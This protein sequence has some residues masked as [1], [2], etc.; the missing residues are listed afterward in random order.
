MKRAVLPRHCV[1]LLFL[2]TMGGMKPLSRLV[3]L[4]VLVFCVFTARAAGK[5]NIVF[6]LSDDHSYPYLGCYGYEG[7]KT[8]HLDRFAAEGIKFHRAFTASP[9]CV[10]SRASIMTG[11]S[12]VA[13]RITRF[14]SPLPKDEITF[15]EILKQQAGYFVGVLGRT[16]HLDGSGR[17]PDVSDKVIEEHGLKTFKQRFD[18]VDATGQENIPK[19]MKEYF[20]QRP[21]DKPY[22]LWVN[23]SD[24]H[25]PWNT[26]KNPPDPAKLK[27]PGFLPDLPGLRDD[28]S[29]Y[30][31]EIEHMDGDFKTVLDIIQDRSGLENTL[32]LFMGDNGM[33]FPSGKGSLHDPGLNVPLLAWWPGVIKPGGESRNLISGED[34]APTCL[35]AAGLSV[36][37]RISGV[38]FLP[39][40]RGE[41]FKGRAHI[42]GERGPHGG[43]TFTANTAANAV[44]YSRAARSA[45]YKLIYNVTPNLRYLP[46]DSTGDPGWKEMTAA[47]EKNLLASEFEKLYFTSPRPVYELYDLEK[48]PSELDN[49]AG[50]KELAGVERELKEALQQ[51]MILDYDYLPL[52]IAAD[53]KGA[54][55]KGKESAKADAGREQQFVAKDKDKDGKLSW[56]EFSAGRDPAEAKKWF[57]A[58]DVDKNGFLSREE[59]VTAKVLN[60][61]NK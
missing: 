61:P 36:P 2:L 59:F 10:P 3:W 39:V 29:R 43:A 15:P 33:A 27:L 17:G 12:P 53:P 51:K 20:D 26:G 45:R 25:H 28:L 40:L 34:I 58:R 41:P 44:D 54:A 7:L 1:G 56:A 11:R 35:Q 19:H 32:I 5:P 22:F 14:S 24:P 6:I 42:F 4:A 16:Y 52:P 48:D 50:R 31:G 21:K 57:D 8:P 23:F 9:Q 13:C 46:V 47:H 37:E 18:Y 55:G 30:L 60:P 38:S 49:L